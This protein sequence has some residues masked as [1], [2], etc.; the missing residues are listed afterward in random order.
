M[1]DKQW[2]VLIDVIHGKTFKPLPIGF[3]IDSPWLPNWAGI[4]ILDYYT[5]EEFWFKAN[6]K[7]T[8][9]FPDVIFLPGFWSEFGMCS[10]PSAFGAKCIWDENEFPFAGKIIKSY[11]EISAIQNPSPQRDGLLPFIL[12]RL[13]HY[14]EKINEAGHRIRFAISRGPLNIASF[15]MGST[16]FLLGLKTNPD[17]MRKLL[18][19][20]SDFIIDWLEIQMDRFPS[21]DGVL[22][23]DDIVGF[24]G[25]EDFQVFVLPYLKKIYQSMDVS[26]KFF[27]NDAPGLVSAPYLREIGINLLNFSFQ[28]SVNEMKELT[29]NTVTLLGNIPPREVLAE[30]KPEQV[31]EKVS[32]LINYA[33]DRSR[34]IVSCGGGMP[35]GVSTEN[36]TAFIKAVREK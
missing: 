5:N 31:K 8:Q 28:H 1:T 3:I 27:H 10:E 4:S 16:E 21:I 15:L 6:L 25:E 9:T 36:I 24:L 2:K 35:P 30:G 33:K 11:D 7:A 34:L 13:K 17:E 26:V 18:Q 29:R 12:R 14:E 20:V 22:I 23:L 32:E 19:I